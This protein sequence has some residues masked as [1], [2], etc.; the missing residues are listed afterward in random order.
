MRAPSDVKGC[1]LV[2]ER[3]VGGANYYRV[4]QP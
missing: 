1:D 4:A 3:A 2:T